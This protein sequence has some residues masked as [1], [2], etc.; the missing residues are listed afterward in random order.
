MNQVSKK[1]GL[2][3]VHPLYMIGYDQDDEISLVDLWIAL[4]AFKRLFL[5]S[6]VALMLLGII[7][8]TQF[9]SPKYS[10]STVLGIAR[11]NDSTIETPAA[12][13]NRINVLI[14]PDLTK[15]LMIDHNMALFN[16]SV[17]NPKDTNLIVIENRVTNENEALFAKFQKQ[18]GLSVIESHKSLLLNLNADLHRRIS[19]AQSVGE[20]NSLSFN[21]YVNKF[22]LGAKSSIQLIKQRIIQLID[23]NRAIQSVVNQSKNMALIPLVQMS[24]NNQTISDLLTKQLDLEQ[25]LSSNFKVFSEEFKQKELKILELENLI[26]AEVTQISGNG[27]LSLKPVGLSHGKAYAIVIALSFFL[28]FC[29]TLVAI[30]RTKVTER[31]AEKA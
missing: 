18:I 15:K 27:K 20:L 6:L 25:K 13:L 29:L 23:N 2:E 17:T 12:A 26:Q 9:I 1:E 16:T 21:D 30:F 31:L 22:E 3:P 8:I 4:F 24:D 19:L 10:M 28:S 14:L 11:Y 5:S 7:A